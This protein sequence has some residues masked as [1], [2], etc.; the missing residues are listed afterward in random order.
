MTE[1]CTEC[2]N[3]IIP[4]LSNHKIIR[5][6]YPK[7][8]KDHMTYHFCEQPKRFALANFDNVM[9]TWERE[10]GM[11][12]YHSLLRCKETSELFHKKVMEAL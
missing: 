5:V 6:E 3:V 10:D 12:D 4:I 9:I 11:L 7:T 1:S 8:A 2:R